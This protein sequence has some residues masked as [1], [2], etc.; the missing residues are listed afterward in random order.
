MSKPFARVRSEQVRIVLVRPQSPG[1]IGA[2]ARAM[3]NM[4]LRH[5]VL[6]A[7]ERFPHP[8]ARMMACD[9]QGLLQQARV[10]ATLEE[11][12]A[13]CHWLVGTSARRRHFRHP[14]LAPRQ[15]AQKL[16]A[17]TQQ[18]RVGVLFGPEDSG[19]TRAELDLC[20]ELLTIPTVPAATSLNLAQAV[21]IVCY[22][23]LLASAPPPPLPPPALA[24]LAEVTAMYEHV[25]QTLAIRGFA[26]DAAV[27]RVLEGLRR[28]FDRAGLERRDV[29][30][31]RGIARQLAWALQHPGEAPDPPVAEGETTP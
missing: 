8:E 29:A 2:V 3:H 22:E 14:P 16:P 21:L 10:C 28:I 27:T 9:A 1:N 12:V 18:H 25:R 24:P 6:V 20:H 17:L 7:P 31:L 13:D 19:L 4:G 5:L 15:W 26:G 11:A 30:L 23:I